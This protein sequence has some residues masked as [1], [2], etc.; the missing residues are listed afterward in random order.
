MEGS[1]V[2]TSITTIMLSLALNIT[3][4]SDLAMSGA[5]TL[6]GQVLA[7]GSVEE[8]LKKAVRQ[9]KFEKD[10]REEELRTQV[11]K[12]KIGR[13]SREENNFER[14]ARKQK[15]RKE[16]RKIGEQ[17]EIVL[18]LRVSFLFRLGFV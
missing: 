15:L 11:R 16:T 12:Q 4:P 1:S 5:I 10:L 13:R 2:G 7:V 9:Q 14:G 17:V 8:K 18:L 6:E 3:I